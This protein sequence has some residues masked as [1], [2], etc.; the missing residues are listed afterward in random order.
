MDTSRVRLRPRA[1]EALLA[2]TWV[3]LGL[4]PAGDA[5]I[6]ARHLVEADL[7]GHPSHGIGLWP[8]YLDAAATG[9]L[10]ATAVLR[11]AANLG[12]L[13]VFDANHGPGQ[14]MAHHAVETA[15]HRAHAQGHCVL[16]LRDAHH[17]GRIGTYAEQCAAQGI[18]SIHL[19]NVPTSAIV[20]PW[21]GP[22]GRLGTNPFCAGFPVAGGEPVIVD[23]A[24][25]RWAG[26][27]V[28]V[29][30]DNGETL[31]DGILLDEAG[32]PTNDPGKLWSEP[33][34]ALLP[35]GEHKGYAL[36]LAIELLAG[37]LVGGAT[38]NGGPR[39]AILNSMFSILILSLIHIS[40]PTRHG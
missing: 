11:P 30:M 27:K 20:A 24:T 40:E 26:G 36:A 8:L 18:V 5:A 38:Q 33:R 32:E 6:L 16:A 31:P 17:V 19:V 39:D 10:D 1:I 14:I 22:F 34:G 3:G 25:S 15:I 2:A 13:L 4:G 35:M 29:A 9:A 23:L 21:G 12:A 28:R 7:A 37:A